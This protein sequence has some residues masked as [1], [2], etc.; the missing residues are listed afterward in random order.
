MF[1][2]VLIANRGEIAVR[3]VRALR[4][5]GIAS[6]A[7]HARDDAA[8]LHAQLADTAVALDATGPCAYLDAAALIAVAKAQG[9]DAVHPGY[10]FLSE[11]AD[12]AQACA[13]AG[14]VFIGPTPEQLGLF[15]DKAR[16][17]ELATQCDVPVM[18]GSP[19][20]V[21]LAQAQ[22]FFAQQHAQGAGVM[23]K[24]IG[25]GGGRGMRAV[26]DAQ[27]LPEAHARCMSE[28]KAAFGIE[29]VYVE[30]LMLNARH[31]EVQVIGDGKAVA[32]LG[33]RECTLQRR[34]QK[35]VEIAPS[36]SLPEALRAQVT[37][38]ALRMAKAVGYRGLGTFEFLV[39][40]SSATLP[41]VFIEAN[42]RLQVEHT[43][44]EAV[45]GLDLVQLQIA[46][47]AGQ[48]LA[49]L[50]VEDDRTAPQRGFAVQWRIN[51][52]TLDAQGNARPSGGTLARFDLP[53]GPGVRVDTHGY[54]GLA[55]S[56]HYD[57]LLAKLIVH[58]PS[59]RFEDALR[60]SLRAL[61]ECHIDGIATNLALLRAIAAR[62]EFATQAVHTRFVEAHLGDLLAAASALEKQVRKTVAAP[63]G[64]M[65][66]AGDDDSDELT[67]KAP[68]PARLVQLEV[69]V[70]D[71]LPVGAQLG[72]LEAMKMEHLLHAPVAGRVVALQAAPGD[73]LVEGQSLVRLEAV[74]AQAVQAEA[75]AEHDLDAI[76]PD[77]QKVI[78][79]HAFTLDANRKAAVDK[80][81]A[82][83][84]R[85]ARENIADLCDTVSDP[86]NFIEY[87]ALAI[88]A[89]TRR[90]TLEDL[91]VNTPADGMVTG[92]GS[93]NAK[94]FG[95]E[96]SRCAVLAYDYTVLA[97]TQGMRNHHKTDRLLAVAH[98]LK[99][100]VVLFA[101]G[102]GGRPGDTDMPIVAGLNNHTFS[103]FAALSGKVPVVGIVHG[104]C[105]A[106][107]AAL[108]GCA[109]VIIAT[110]GSN[111]GMSG[112]AM[113]E[114]GG[115]GT[116]APE[117]IGPSGVQSRNGVIDILVEDEAAAV[118]AAKQYLSY[119]QGATTDWQCADPRTLR[120]VVPENRL[121]V[122]DVR[123]AMRG[124]ADT[125][126]LLEL[127]AG[128]GAGIVTALAR[129]EGRPV[130]LMANNPHHLG[131]AIDVE[132]ADKSARFMQLCNAHGLPIVSLCD[133]PGFMVGPEIEAQAQVRHVCRMFMVAS[134]LRVPFFAVVLRKGYGLGAQAM[135]A[136]GFDAPV[137]T[138]AWPT[139]E[140]GAMGLEGAVRLGFRKE[141]AAAPE[142]A[143]RDAL[144][145]KLVGQ[146][147]EN[148]EAIH[149]AQT[150]EI[151]AVIDPADTRTWLVR[152]LSSA[153]KAQA[154]AVAYVDTW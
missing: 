1:S 39:D 43:V 105:F 110:R 9:C 141:L 55:P 47:A 14:L 50:G 10:G 149:M 6:V 128:F 114:G 153:T 117:Q 139:G 3:L 38:A 25:G 84:G 78:D 133:T 51:A 109:D 59:Q 99:L 95:P 40:A 58:S 96:A 72:V 81:H 46:V 118:A 62:P 100:P 77:L 8:A 74:D 80:R 101:E 136:G 22:A 107:N 71:V 13:D 65:P 122:Y 85:T 90:R 21:T 16:A 116:F 94:Q 32:S 69:E 52:E 44:T 154:P 60:R 134:H 88:A 41:F 42:P 144:F 83:G 27:E 11:R 76:R 15:G 143:E 20:A 103:Q 131:G 132:A 23:V 126:S 102:G 124:V 31:I 33:E 93:V 66:V 73:Y 140:F 56:P 121:R 151:D 18:P 49:E 113:I 145:R 127:R 28:A 48:P 70:G 7:V 68:M 37:Q 87:G 57:T 86:A 108:L 53:A 120:H 142:G 2:K 36:P 135:T 150:L 147:Y 91:V 89:Q 125:G 29:G 17:R 112:P 98:Q 4:D 111:I 45:T 35:L 34:F 12:F 137:F 148:G 92:L 5:L 79:R 75:R 82:Q 119:F 104:R 61:D 146:Q 123:A 97:G 106:G 67:V 54:A 19:G 138:V 130:G 115:L 63:V 30:R 129:I 24:A 64:Q 26:L 152:G